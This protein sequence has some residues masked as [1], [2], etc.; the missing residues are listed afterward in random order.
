MCLLLF[1]TLDCSNTTELGVLVSVEKIF[2]YDSSGYF[3]CEKNFLLYD[4]TAKRKAEANETFCE[5]TATW[6]GEQNYLCMAG[7]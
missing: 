6:K 3:I 4:I 7:I 5:A 1:L 2:Q